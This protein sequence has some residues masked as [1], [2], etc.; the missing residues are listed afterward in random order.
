[1]GLFGD[2]LLL[3]LNAISTPSGI[4]KLQIEKADSKRRYLLPFSCI[5][6]IGS[7][8]TV[9]TSNHP[10]SLSKKLLEFVENSIIQ[11]EATSLVSGFQLEIYEGSGHILYNQFNPHFSQSLSGLNNNRLETDIENALLNYVTTVY[12]KA[13]SNDKSN[14]LILL[15]MTVAFYQQEIVPII[16]RINMYDIEQRKRLARTVIDFTTVFYKRWDNYKSIAPGNALFME[17]VND[18]KKFDSYL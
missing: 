17:T 10:H 15:L 13:N 4:F 16:K 6:L 14:L 1:M 9:L 5:S 3:K 18:A 7:Q 11:Y 12:V 8:L 2:K